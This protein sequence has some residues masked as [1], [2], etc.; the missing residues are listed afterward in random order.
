V[1]SHVVG[2]VATFTTKH[3]TKGTHY[4]WAIFTDNAGNFVT[5][6]GEGIQIIN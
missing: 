3:L 6:N 5:S 2:G 4:I 1:T